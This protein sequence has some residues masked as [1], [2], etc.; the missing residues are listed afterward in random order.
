MK[1]GICTSPNALGD[2]ARTLE[3]LADAGAAYVEWPVGFL[4]ASREEFE[5]LRAL[6]EKAPIRPEAFCAFLPPHHRLTGPDVELGKVLDYAGEAIRRIGQIGGS[7]VVLG[8]GGARKVPVG[9][10]P[11]EARRQFIEF[12]CELAP[13][14]AEQGVR[15]AIEPLN[16]AED[17]LLNSVRD[18]ARITEEIGQPAIR[19]L[20][21]FYHMNEEKESADS[22]RDA[23]G[24][25][26]HTHVADTGRVAPGFAGDDEADFRAFFGALKSVGYDARCS[27]EGKTD[28]LARQA[29]LLLAFLQARWSKA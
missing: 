23:G 1:F 24:L 20:A 22:I 25:I 12:A 2:P 8:S 7:I 17:N 26:V 6:A 11:D 29:P 15:V 19:L 28:D 27:F 14:A 3:T 9:F 21:D 10:S 13:L 18:G 4:M 5:R 16:K